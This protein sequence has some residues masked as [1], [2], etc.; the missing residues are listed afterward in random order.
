MSVNAKELADLDPFDLF[1]IEARRLD[2]Y[3]SRL[4]DPQWR[5]PS[6]CAGWSVRDVLAHLAGEETYNQACL[7]GDV[8]GFLG[9]LKEAGIGGVHEFNEWSVRRRRDVPVEEVLAEWRTANRVTRERMRAR[10]RDSELTT[11]AG[12]Y[13]T[14]LQAFH[15]ASEYATHADDV[16]APVEAS[17]EPG[18]THWRARVARFVLW[19][20]GQP[21]QVEW[22]TDGRY[23]VMLGDRD[24]ELS[25]AEFVTA[26][27]ARLP[28]DHP[29]DPDLREALACLA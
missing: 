7:D 6:R 19:E 29:L 4:G 5:Q 27:V 1:D 28:D 12:P 8:A 20:Q 22:V 10:G 18:R 11:L 15:Y 26:T 2:R 3:F 24:D 21:A 14:G 25:E 16:G 17:E 23:H 13:P 9:L